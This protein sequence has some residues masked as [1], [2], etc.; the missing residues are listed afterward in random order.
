[1]ATVH[2]SSID[3]SITELARSAQLDRPGSRLD[4]PE[5]RVDGGHRRIRWHRVCFAVRE[6]KA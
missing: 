5:P 6:Q 1:M 3:A 4:D 2:R